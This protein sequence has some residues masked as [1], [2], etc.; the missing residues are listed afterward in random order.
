[1][2]VTAA[3]AA[4]GGVTAGVTGGT[5]GLTV[6]G[7]AGAIVGVVPAIFTFGLS[8]PCFAMIGG[9]VGL[10]AG[11]AV[12]G[13][14]GA[15]GGGATGYTVYAKRNV[16]RDGANACALYSKNTFL[17][18]KNPIEAQTSAAITKTV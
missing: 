17:A 9:G 11:T 18:I 12:G 1:M 10:C 13:T 15:V 8:I 4:V 5:V 2:G 7:V 3:S 16:I 6:G 14:A